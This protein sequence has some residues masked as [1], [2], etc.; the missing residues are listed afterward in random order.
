MAARVLVEREG[1]IGW[2]VFDQ[3]A[4]RNAITVEMWS[5]IPEVAR[6]LDADDSVRVIVMRGAAGT[7]KSWLATHIAPWI[8]GE[9]IRSDV[10]AG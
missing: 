4:R 5:A 2:V 1:G 8:R 9:V 7:G 6:E 3:V 10:Q